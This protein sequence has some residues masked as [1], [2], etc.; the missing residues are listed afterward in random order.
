MRRR[1]SLGR[2]LWMWISDL[3]RR[4]NAQVKRV[5]LKESLLDP[6]MPTPLVS[7]PFGSD[8]SSQ[9]YLAYKKCCDLESLASTDRALQRSSPPGLVAARLLGHLLVLSKNGRQTLAQE[10]TDASGNAVLVD[11]AKFYI[12]HFVK[13]CAYSVILVDHTLTVLLVKRASGRTPAPT[14][15][16]SRPS[17]EDERNA[18][19]SINDAASLNHGKAKAA[20]RSFLFL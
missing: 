16:P 4:H 3:S 9:P 20:V 15:H 18:L 2:S 11:L 12:T 17:F 5:R 14:E 19:A 8:P 6:T 10:I 1:R 13:V 7:N